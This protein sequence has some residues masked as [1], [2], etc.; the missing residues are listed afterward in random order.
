[1][2]LFFSVIWNSRAFIGLSF[3][4]CSLSYYTFYLYTDINATTSQWQMFYR[5]D[6]Y[7]DWVFAGGTPRAFAFRTSGTKYLG[8]FLQSKLKTNEIFIS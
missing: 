6:S 5:T 3:D 7:S 1:M 2:V 8:T 4:L